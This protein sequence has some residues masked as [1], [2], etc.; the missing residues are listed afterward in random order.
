M[1]KRKRYFFSYTKG[2]NFIWVIRR[3]LDESIVPID[4]KQDLPL[5][6]AEIWQFPGMI[7]QK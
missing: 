6:L 7:L 1:P 2:K 4:K 3:K 5:F